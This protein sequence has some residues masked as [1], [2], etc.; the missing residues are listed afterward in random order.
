MGKAAF[1]QNE[2][3]N[4]MIDEIIYKVKECTKIKTGKKLGYK[5]R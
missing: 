3:I 1:V 4:E 2:N 5:I